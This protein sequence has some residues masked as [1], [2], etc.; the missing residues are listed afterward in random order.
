M[1][2]GLPGRVV[3]VAEPC[4]VGIGGQ[5]LISVEAGHTVSVESA[6]VC[7]LAEG[8]HPDGAFPSAEGLGDKV[9][10]LRRAIGEADRIRR[11]AE[12]CGQSG[13]QRS[14]LRFRVTAKARQGIGQTL[15]EHTVVDAAKHVGTEI[16]RYRRRIPIEVVAMSVNHY[17]A[18]FYIA[19][20]CSGVP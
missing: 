5:A 15:E 20:A 9:D 12:E 14:R 6:G 16:A 17:L 18:G 7:V 2:A 3:R 1:V 10:G 8:G 4:D 13:F 19:T 11:D